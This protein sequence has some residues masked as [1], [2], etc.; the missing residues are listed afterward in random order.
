MRKRTVLLEN[1]FLVRIGSRDPGP[2]ILAKQPLVGTG[3]ELFVFSGFGT[4]AAAICFLAVTVCFFGLI[5][6]FNSL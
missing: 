6:A 2:H 1:L 5:S 3:G 4:M